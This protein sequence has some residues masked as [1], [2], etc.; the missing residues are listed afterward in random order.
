MEK[1]IV[2]PYEK[3]Q[4]LLQS[5]SGTQSEASP[6]KMRNSTEPEQRVSKGIK[7]SKI[8]KIKKVPTVPLPPP[9]ER[10]FK[11]GGVTQEKTIDWISF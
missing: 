11:R 7:I 6:E 2:I 4:R 5:G 9:G 10:D 8:K 1:L 3:Y